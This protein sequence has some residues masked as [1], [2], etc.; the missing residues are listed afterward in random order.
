[1]KY[2]LYINQVQAIELGITNTT[3]AIILD[4]LAHCSAWAESIVIDDDVYY[5]VARQKIC[6]ELPLLSIKPDTA[7][8]HMKSLHEIGLID[9]IKDGKKDLIKLSDLGKKYVFSTMSEKNPNKSETRK[10]IQ[11][12][13]DLNSKKLGKKSEF[14]SEKN[15]TYNTTNINNTTNNNIIVKS[16]KFQKP[17]HAQVA[18]YLKEKQQQLDID[19][20][21]DYYE[22]KDWMIGKNRMKNWKSA[23]N[24][25]LRNE[26]NYATNKQRKLTQAERTE[27]AVNELLNG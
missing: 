19:Y 3:Q 2:N 10:K 13:S 14:N 7:Y 1:M 18:E 6:Y 26:K 17:T 9:Y 8:R 23:I 4:L 11:G 27:I 5:W 25:W 15:P 16:K 22:S 21:I 20:F 24:N 12:N